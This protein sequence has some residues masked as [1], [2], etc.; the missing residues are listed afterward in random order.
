MKSFVLV[1]MQTQREYGLLN[2]RSMVQDK[3]PENENL[4]FQKQLTKHC[5]DRPYDMIY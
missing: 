1:C 5:D 2:A 3:E 4:K